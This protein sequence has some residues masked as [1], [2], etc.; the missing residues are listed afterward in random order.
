VGPT[1]SSTAAWPSR[2]TVLER[3]RERHLRR[4]RR[5]RDG[6]V[7]L[8]Q[9]HQRRVPRQVHRGG[10]ALWAKHFGTGGTEYATD[11][12]VDPTQN[13]VVVTGAFN[14]LVDLGTGSLTTAGSY[15]A[16]LGRFSQ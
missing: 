10:A 9:R 13:G 8:G 12:A 16:F 7:R 6:R 4:Q 14:G 11:V 2:P 15:D 5:L 3:H 1:I